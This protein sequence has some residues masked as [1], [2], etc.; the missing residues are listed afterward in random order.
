MI[1][2][3]RKLRHATAWLRQRAAEHLPSVVVFALIAFIAVAAAGYGSWW[4][5]VA[6][7]VRANAIAFQAEQRQLG[8]ELTWDGIRTEGFPYRV[9][10]TLSTLHFMAPD[11][12]AAYDG[13]RV[14]V[15]VEPLALHRVAVSL[16]GQQHFF[17]AKE[18]W[19]ET[20]VRADR[21][22]LSLS[23][24]SGDQHVALDVERL[25][26]AAKVDATDFK[27]IVEKANGGVSVR[28]DDKGGSWRRVELAARLENIAL[29]GDFE[30]PLGP[31]IGL[32]E[33]DAGG[34]LPSQALDASASALLAAWRREGTPIELKRFELEWGGV[35]VG[36]TGAFTLDA[37]GLPEGSLRL[38]LGNHPRILELLETLGWITHE[39]RVAAKPLLDVFAFVGKDAQRR[40]T[41]PL[42]I[43]NGE[44]YLGPARVGTFN[45]PT[46]SAQLMTTPSE[47]PA[48]IG[49]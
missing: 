45:P 41:V 18:R 8:R 13:D 20:N 1:G 19:I 34:R 12:G 23:E 36:A 24:R 6:E 16:E 2:A 43:R 27:F 26:G 30:L 15:H 37:N 11:R 25:T 29:L 7:E 48:S 9:E 46:A 47:T 21:A 4:R 40:I 33:I 44:I 28:S 22:I 32:L 49:P 42:S 14:V 39:T 3:L 35:S 17:Y 31:S 10:T 5:L 38:K